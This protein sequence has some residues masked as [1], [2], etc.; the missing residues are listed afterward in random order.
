MAGQYKTR[1]PHCGAQFKIT[2][3][4]LRQA[5]GAVRC[6]SCLQIFQASDYLL[7]GP[8]T[9][10]PGNDNRWAHALE[11]NGDSAAPDTAEDTA[12]HGDDDDDGLTIE[13]MELSDSFLN[14]GSDEDDQGLGEDFSDM[15]GA[16]RDTHNDSADEAWAEALL[17]ELENEDETPPPSA[18]PRQAPAPEKERPAAP[19]PE[20]ERPTSKASKAVPRP[21]VEEDDDSLFGG[22]DLFGDDFNEEEIALTPPTRP[23]PP[24]FHNT[25][26][27]SGVIKWG[28]LSLL[29]VIILLAQYA[30]F[31]FERL[32]RQP[33]WR[34]AYA[35]V[36]QVLGCRLPSRSDISKLR[37]AN[38]VVRSNPNFQNSL[39][40]DAILFNEADYPQP[41]PVLELSFTAMNGKAVASRRFLPS[42][43]RQGD[44]SDMRTMP[45]GTP[46]HISLEIVDPGDQA[47]NYNLR[48]LPA[49]D[50]NDRVSSAP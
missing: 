45:P 3:E 41:F 18:A 29:A 19:A 10:A 9:P 44:L 46:L 6:G 28:L 49:S 37:G 48:L 47:V 5:R 4:H 7:D 13:G 38:L 11:G 20:A 15:Q 14:L 23:Q 22:L 26:D 12:R 27:W 24:Q 35:Q 42:E 43:Y 32:A 36:C 8:A 33:Q 40:V 50:S 30:F 16:G 34:P 2:D 17:K 31:N 21:P 25:R 39:I 1:C